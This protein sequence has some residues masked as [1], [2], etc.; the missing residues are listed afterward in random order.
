MIHTAGASFTV[1]YDAAKLQ[2]KSVSSS[3][4]ATF[5]AQGI[6]PSSVTV[7]TPA[8][9]YSKGLVDNPSSG[10]VM[11]AAAQTTNG[12]AGVKTLFTL[13]FDTISGATGSAVIN[14]TPSTITNAAAGYPSA[15]A[16]P[17]LV[18]IGTNNTYPA[19]TP[20]VTPDTITIGSTVD[21]DGDGIADSWE[22]TYFGNLTTANSST[23]TDGDGYS[24]LNE[25][26]NNT[27]PK[28]RNPSNP[29]AKTEIL[30]RNTST[31]QNYVWY[32]DGTTA[33]GGDYLTT[34]PD[35]NWTIV[36]RNDFNGDGKPDILWRN[37]STG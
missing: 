7:G 26:L 17:M 29:N 22:M 23:D 32:M 30:W 18:G 15:T 1:T 10:K 37:T 34:V 21:S 24:D 14:V 36:G 5:A 19:I 8:V 25:F 20:S 11:L 31:G 28:I 9:T 27:D 13:T 35:L 6:T 33:T 12:T 16:V 2:Y 4:F 3:F